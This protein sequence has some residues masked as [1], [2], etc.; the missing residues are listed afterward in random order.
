MSRRDLLPGCIPE[1]DTHE[2]HQS[3]A[4]QATDATQAA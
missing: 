4:D 1:D 3:P 2:Y